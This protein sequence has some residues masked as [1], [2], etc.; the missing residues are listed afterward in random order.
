MKECLKVVFHGLEKK[1]SHH[2]DD[3]IWYLLTVLT[4]DLNFDVEMVKSGEHIHILLIALQLL[5]TFKQAKPWSVNVEAV[6]EAI[7]ILFKF[8]VQT[9]KYRCKL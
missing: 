7:S 5:I 3:R 6:K 8:L 1:I 9:L 2:F 4:N